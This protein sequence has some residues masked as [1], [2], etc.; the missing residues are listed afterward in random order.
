MLH[1]LGWIGCLLA[2]LAG[3]VVH[4]AVTHRWSAL[5]PNPSR[6]EAVHAHTITLADYVATD[7]PSELPVKERSRVTCR[8]YTSP[9]GRTPATVSIT[10]GPSGAVS[11]HTP[12][13]CYPGSGFKM[14]QAPRTESID[15]PNGGK[16]AYLVAEFEKKTATTYERHRV[17]WSWT[18]DGNWGVP[19]RPRFAFL[20]APELFKLYVV[21]AVPME[22][23]DKTEGDSP[24]VRAFVTAAFGQYSRLLSEK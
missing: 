20:T 12:D 18:I 5:S 10:S 21:T 8:Q 2:V 22:D 9:S 24:A 1:K 7:F 13:V 14:V 11:T 19:D 6:S 4:G 23:A 15:L 3:A 17:R 16:A